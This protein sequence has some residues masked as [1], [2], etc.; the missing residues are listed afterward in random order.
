M[1]SIRVSKFK[2]NA[3]NF[4]RNYKMKTSPEGS[5]EEA[6]VEDEYWNLVTKAKCTKVSIQMRG[7]R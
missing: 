7:M 3:I 2:E 1:Q 5:S 4:S 6:T